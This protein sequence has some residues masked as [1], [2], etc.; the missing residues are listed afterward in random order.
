MPGK[1]SPKPH[2]A[3]LFPELDC[4]PGFFLADYFAIAESF[5]PNEPFTV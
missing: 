4:L 3:F 5:A 2:R 1:R